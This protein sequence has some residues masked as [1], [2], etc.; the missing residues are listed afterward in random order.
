MSGLRAL[1]GLAIVALVGVLAVMGSQVMADPGDHGPRELPGLREAPHIPVGSVPVR[2]PHPGHPLG[3]PPGQDGKPGKPSGCDKDVDLTST[4]QGVTNVAAKKLKPCTNADIDTFVRNPKTYVVQAGGQERAWTQTDVS[5]PANPAVVGAFRWSGGRGKNT[6]T[7]DVKTFQQG[8]NDYIVLGLE[9]LAPV[10]F[11]GVVIV[12]VNDPANPAIE[13]QFIGDDWCD[14]HNVFV[15]EDADGD[16]AFVYATADNTADLRVLDVLAPGG[17]VSTPLEVGRYSRTD[18]GFGGSGFYDDRYVHDVTVRDGTVYASYWRAGLDI[19]PASLIKSGTI[20]ETHGSVDNILP[21]AFDSGKPF[22]VHHAHASSNRT[23]VFVQDEIEIASGAEVVQM[24]RTASGNKVDGLAQGIDVPVIPAHNLEIRDDIVPDRLH[25][26]WYQAGLQAWDFDGT[27]FDRP[28]PTPRTAVQYHQVQTEPDDTLDS[29][30]WGVRLENITV[31]GNT[32]TYIFQSDRNFGLIVDCVGC[33]VVIPPP[34]GGT[35]TVKGKVTDDSTG[36]N[37]G[38]VLVEIVG[39]DK[40][41][42]TN[43]GG[44]YS[45]GGV[46]EGDVTVRAS[47][48]GYIPEETPATVVADQNT[49]VDF[50]LAPA[51]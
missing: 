17:S 49:V 25:V 43:N 5:D 47:K 11:C 23:F 31:D 8:S 27:G 48:P 37:L 40:S 19:F 7:P 9:R 38:D 42:T 22:L 16:G 46:S 33:S 15:E 28:N 29:G 14:T 2:S 41:D 21:D 13:S 20:D 6:Y 44:R 45:I 36:R 35:G 39:T 34:A 24:F 3:G 18:R 1:R 50:A 32:N 4:I 30:A 26:G 51:E 12:N 10:A